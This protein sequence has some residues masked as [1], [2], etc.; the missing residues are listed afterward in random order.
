MPALYACY[1]HSA[2]YWRMVGLFVLLTLVT[3]FA[4]VY[5]AWHYAVDGY[6]A[7]LGTVVL[8]WLA[9]RLVPTVR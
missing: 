6:A 3:L 7:I 1:A 2:G 5:L 9:G 8:W 4:S